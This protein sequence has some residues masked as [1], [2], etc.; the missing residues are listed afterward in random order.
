MA[1]FEG[2]NFFRQRLVLA[3]LTGR[4]VHIEGI[5]E[6]ENE[7]GL[8]E[9]EA[10]FIRLLDKLTNGSRIEVSE[11]GTSLFYQP[12]VLLGG[13]L[14]HA[15][16]SQRSIGYFLEPLMMLAPFS[17]QPLRITLRGPTNG[18]HD[19][20]VDYYNMCVLPLLKKLLVGGHDISLKI[21]RRR[22]C[23]S[24]DGEVI[25][26]C[27]TIRKMRP[28]TLEEEGKVKRVRG[29][30]YCM[31]VN[32][33]MA[34]RMVD[35][36]RAVLN[37]YLPDVYINTDCVSGT[38]AGSTPGYG[39]ILISESNEGIMHASEGISLGPTDSNTSI[40]LPEDIGRDTAV[41]LV[42]EIYR[43][44]CADTVTQC[45]P[46]LYMA[47]GQQ[48]VSKI[49]LGQLSPYTIQFLRHLED[50]LKLR[51]KISSDVTEVGETVT[52]SCV[53]IGFSNISKGVR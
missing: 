18:L 15:C 50:F 22:I 53:G 37:N 3:T 6:N 1:R 34:N 19:P 40:N 52:L 46:L 12:G 4:N 26:T 25:F 30:A 33:G 14:E 24:S 10:G 16:S 32:P 23:P 29:I 51:Y 27:P 39:L 44:G 5:R 35:S 43:G 20:S 36:A 45:I 47:L 9:Y 28:F 31:R 48:D 2:C 8:Q 38:K 11:T 7:P 21:V 41:R 13:T 17:K 49:T 42:E